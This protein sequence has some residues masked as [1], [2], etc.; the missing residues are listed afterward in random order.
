MASPFGNKNHYI[1]GLSH[2]RLDNI[3]RTMKARCYKET[4]VKY[5]MYGKRGIKMCEEWLNDKTKFFEWANNNGYR[6]DL[7]I[8][9]IDNNGDY[10]PQNC[11]WATIHEQANNTRT[12][13][14]V[15]YHGKRCTM[16]ELCRELGINYKR[17]HQKYRKEGYSL[18]EAI[19]FCQSY[20]R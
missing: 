11:R 13:V 12:N 8:D 20:K 6:E 7:T 17:F 9:R 5:H 14:Y 2:T 19:D 3:Y 4:S 10:T 1:H 15:A 16:A 18:Q